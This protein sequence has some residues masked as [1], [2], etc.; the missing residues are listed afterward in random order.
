[1]TEIKLTGVAVPASATTINKTTTPPIDKITSSIKI[2][3]P[4]I[5]VNPIELINTNTEIQLLTSTTV[6]NNTDNDT[7]NTDKDDKQQ[8]EL[9]V[10]KTIIKNKQQQ[11]INK[12]KISELKKHVSKNKDD[13]VNDSVND[14]EADNDNDDDDDSQSLNT[15]DQLP[16]QEKDSDYEPD[17]TDD[18]DDDE[19]E[20]DEDEADNIVKDKSVEKV[21]D[22]NKLSI[23]PKSTT[24]GTKVTLVD[25]KKII[26]GNNN[27]NI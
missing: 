21:K 16:E 25:V 10:N 4:I 23:P 12:N 1:M 7:D 20:D 3:K 15:D 9:L 27:N 19:I 14:D 26:L 6:Q 8:E 13:D 22:T 18:T 17:D 24:D 2:T 11:Y 5:Q